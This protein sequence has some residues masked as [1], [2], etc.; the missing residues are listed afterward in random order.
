MP[1]R[2]CRAP[3]GLSCSG[4]SERGPQAALGRRRRAGGREPIPGRAPSVD[5]RIAG[6]SQQAEQ[7]EDDEPGRGQERREGGTQQP[8]FPRDGGSGTS[9]MTAAAPAALRRKVASALGRGERVFEEA[10][11]SWPFESPAGRWRRGYGRAASRSAELA[12]GSDAVNR[13]MGGS[14]PVPRG[15]ANPP[16]TARVSDWSRGVW[17]AAPASPASRIRG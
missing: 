17:L 4:G 7:A 1:D 5:A 8:P 13:R 10:V 2:C 15:V 16:V 9:A 6:L 12:G 3:R 11:I 14:Q